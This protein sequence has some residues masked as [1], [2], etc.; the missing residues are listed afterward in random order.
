MSNMNTEKV[1]E[2]L[3]DVAYPGFKKN[4]VSAGFIQNIDIKDN[5]VTV[6]F[7]PITNKAEKID[8]MVKDIHARLNSIGE[9]EKININRFRPY[10]DDSLSHGQQMTPLQAELLAEGQIPD[11]DVLGIDMSVSK[12][13]LGRADM[14]PDAGYCEDGPSVPEGPIEA[15]S[16]EYEGIMPVYQWEIDPHDPEADSGGTSLTLKGWEFHLWW[17]VHSKGLVYASIQAMREDTTEHE[18]KAREHPVGRSEAVNLVYDLER[19]G[20]VAI[21]GTVGDFRPFVEAFY[22]GY[23]IEKK[24]K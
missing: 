1:L 21:Y 8:Q 23:E 12:A 20:V 24:N 2:C 11:P 9:F 3:R 18:G 10:E 15:G 5:V 6:D 7:A 16:K 4:V 14:A 13:S 19:K 17:Q 22:E